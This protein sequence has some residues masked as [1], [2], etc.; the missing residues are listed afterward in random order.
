MHDI[1]Y[2]ETVIADLQWFRKYKPI[3]GC[4]ANAVEPFG[5]TLEELAQSVEDFRAA[6]ALPVLTLEDI[7]KSSPALGKQKNTKTIS[8]EQLRLQ[9]GLHDAQE[10]SAVYDDAMESSFRHPPH[11]QLLKRQTMIGESLKHRR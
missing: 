7:P 6:L 5:N 3:V 2:T 10:R 1:A 9:L 11:Q 4:T 8:H